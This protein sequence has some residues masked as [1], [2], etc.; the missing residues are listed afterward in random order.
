MLLNK[1]MKFPSKSISQ[2]QIYISGKITQRGFD[3][4]TLEQRLMLLTEE[5]GE[6]NKACRKRSGIK[7]GQHSNDHQ[8]GHE[9]ADVINMIF[10]VAIELGIDVEA[11]YSD[12]ETEIDQRLYSK[13]NCKDLE[14]R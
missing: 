11:E 10:A 8:I 9:I 3:D 5:I 13:D 1:R 7:T 12:K 14:I 6:L 2:L 4:E